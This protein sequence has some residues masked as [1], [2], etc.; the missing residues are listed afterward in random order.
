[1]LEEMSDAEFMALLDD[2]PA[3]PPPAPEPITAPDVLTAVD[4]DL[5][6]LLGMEPRARF[7]ALMELREKVRTERTS[8]IE[9][10]RDKYEADVERLWHSIANRGRKP[11]HLDKVEAELE[12]QCRE[13]IAIAK[14]ATEGSRGAYTKAVEIIERMMNVTADEIDVKPKV[15][16]RACYFTTTDEITYNSQPSRLKYAHCRAMLHKFNLDAMGLM[17][18]VR[19]ST[20]GG[21]SIFDVWVYCVESDLAIIRAKTGARMPA[22]VRECWRL[23]AN[24]RVYWSF[25]PA[26]YEEAHG[27][28]HFG[29]DLPPKISEAITE[30]EII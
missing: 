24:P 14:A 6:A 3:P 13:L 11:F 18:E 1:M 8:L 30:P 7:V 10:I 19:E 26:G 9:R 29:H 21:L 16:A 15:H 5:K 17:A 12:P 27:F 23:G 20:T 4:T 22:L 28:D 25:L 2:E